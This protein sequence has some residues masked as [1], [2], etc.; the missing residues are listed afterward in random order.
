[1]E[2]QRNIS[3]VQDS[4]QL[5]LAIFLRRSFLEKSNKIARPN[6]GL[7]QRW[8][9]I[10]LAFFAVAKL[11]SQVYYKLTLNIEDKKLEIVHQFR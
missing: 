7:T 1:M 9:R 2:T 3:F 8:C 5:N 11:E 10:L 4:L 6:G